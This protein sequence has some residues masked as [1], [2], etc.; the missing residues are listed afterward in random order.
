MNIWRVLVC[1]CSLAV[2]AGCGN[3]NDFPETGGTGV[4]GAASAAGT[5]SSGP[6]AWRAAVAVSGTSSGDQAVAAQHADGRGVVVWR[7]DGDQVWS[8][9][10]VGG[11]WS[12]PQRINEGAGR[13]QYPQVAFAGNDI[14]AAWGRDDIWLARFN[15]SGW[16]EGERV[17]NTRGRPRVSLAANAQGHILLSWYLTD[18]YATIYVC[19]FDPASGWSEVITL[20]RNDLLRFSVSPPEVALD[21]AGNAAVVWRQYDNGGTRFWWSR[22]NGHGWSRA[23]LVDFGGDNVAS[24]RLRGLPNEIIAVWPG[25]DGINAR[26]LTAGGWTATER[27]MPTPPA[28]EARALDTNAAGDYLMLQTNASGAEVLMSQAGAWQSTQVATGAT[29]N[30]VVAAGDSGHALAVW[31]GSGGVM[32]AAARY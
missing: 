29:S 12:G 5:E 22:F 2:L 28:A 21:A 15:G 23:E 25:A 7:A 24:L 9:R 1:G 10:L 19:R 20:T 18:R 16:S 14:V 4:S 3:A 8:N 6:P 17:V 26:R 13:G 11:T 27:V 31:Q 32:T 30:P